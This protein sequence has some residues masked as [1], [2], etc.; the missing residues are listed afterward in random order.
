MNL[1]PNTSQIFSVSLCMIVKNEAENLPRCLTSVKPYVDEMIVVDT[2]STDNTVEIAQQ[3]GAKVSYFEWCNDFAAARNYSISQATKDWILVLDADEE[4]IIEVKK[5]FQELIKKPENIAYTIKLDNIGNYLINQTQT[6][7]LRFFRNHLGIKYTGQFHENPTLENYNLKVLESV[8]ISHYGYAEEQVSGK[9]LNRNIPILERL[10]Q[11]KKL[12]LML[13]E[14]LAEMYKN[15]Q[16]L[17]KSQDCYQAALEQLTPYILE[18]TPPKKMNRIPSLIY[19][20]TMQSFEQ[21]DYETAR[22]LCQRGLEWCPSFPPLNYVAGVILNVLGFPLGASAYFKKCIQLG[23]NKTYYKWEAFD[24]IFITTHPAYNL[25]LMYI[26]LNR[27]QDAL[28]ALELAFSFDDKFTIAQEKI[29]SIK[30]YL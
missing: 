2:G 22:L 5:S 25:G 9:N 13:L 21:E 6:Y 17:E 14:C 8:K 10:Y 18:G 12:D 11:E 24:I 23:Q 27:P 28:S 20:L 16:Q 30:Q 7:V 29:N 3:Y 19:A 26:E 4:L 15:T 1:L